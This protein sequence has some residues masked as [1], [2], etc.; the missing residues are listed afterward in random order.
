MLG[1]VGKI[2]PVWL[3]IGLKL[4]IRTSASPRQQRS[5]WGVRVTQ[6]AYFSLLT[7]TNQLLLV[8]FCHMTAGNGV[9]FR[10]HGRTHGWTDKH[11]SQ[12]SYL[13]VLTWRHDW[14]IPKPIAS[15]YMCPGFEA[16]TASAPYFSTRIS[17][18]SLVFSS[19]NTGRFMAT[20]SP[21]RQR[22]FLVSVLNL[23]L[24]I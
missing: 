2:C 8:T 15:M 23:N 6:N 1:A 3:G 7:Y 5:Y 20:F 10:T 9:S 11:G 17:W 19:W 4:S 21:L 14:P 18:G 16:F 22:M 12:N 24:M 13:D